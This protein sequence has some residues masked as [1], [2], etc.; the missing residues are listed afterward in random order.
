MALGGEKAQI[1]AYPSTIKRKTAEAQHL[2][3]N[4]LRGQ[5]RLE[6]YPLLTNTYL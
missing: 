2:L 4:P 5:G 6:K 1:R 3:R